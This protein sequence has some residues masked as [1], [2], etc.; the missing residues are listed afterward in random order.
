MD[1]DEFSP[2]ELIYLYLDGEADAEECREL[3]AALS[4]D[5][6]LQVEFRDALGIQ[7]ALAAEVC[8]GVPPLAVEQVLFRKAGVSLHTLPVG[9]AQVVGTASFV[10][11]LGAARTVLLSFIAALAGVLIAMP[12]MFP[13]WQGSAGNTQVQLPKATQKE[14]LTLRV[15]RQSTA[16]PLLSTPQR[17]RKAIGGGGLASGRQY[18]FAKKGGNLL[19]GMRN[20]IE[21]R[22]NSTARE[23]SV[24]ISTTQQMGV[25]LPT[26]V[27]SSSHSL[28]AQLPA[29]RSLVG[30]TLANGEEQPV[31]KLCA[32]G[33]VGMRVFPWRSLTSYSST[34]IENIAIGGLYQWS[35]EWA[36]G[37]ELGQEVLPLYTAASD[38]SF[39]LRP[40]AQW[41]GVRAHY[42]PEVM[43][44]G[45][46]VQPFAS[47]LVGGTISGP[48]AKS[49]IGLQWQ[50]D[51]RVSLFLAV[52]GTALWYRYQQ[53]WYGLQKLGMSYG[54]EVKF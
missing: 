11:R 29:L 30:G 51:S 2:S 12:S 18:G 26:S 23:P 31:W 16:T 1:R 47:A 48:L 53:Q 10:A 35:E 32:R 8:A 17:Q 22:E 7:R 41:A 37:A 5:A 28:P 21:S 27:S 33:L 44:I 46:G 3:F 20:G 13:L 52:E 49:M 25:L 42:T 54:V 38:G 43:R 40:T 36:I 45:E 24:A 4:C 6:D 9:V 15:P 39:H 34:A 19:G 50:P 14:E